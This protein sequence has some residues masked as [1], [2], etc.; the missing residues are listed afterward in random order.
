MA[1]SPMK[2]VDR[3][4]ALLRYFSVR[5]PELGLSELARLASQDKTTTL[6]CLTALERNGFVEQDSVSRKYRLGLA[7]INL[8]RL[9]EQSF[10]MQAVITPY[11]DQLAKITGETTHATLLSGSELLTAF[12]S[13][14]DRAL[15]VHIDPTVILPVHA[16]ASGIIIAAFASEDIRKALLDTTDFT[17]F[18]EATMINSTQF[19]KHVAEARTLG[20]AHVFMTYE[21]DVI[22][23]AAPIFGS[24][25]AP[26]GAIAVAAVS[27][28]H[29]PTL[30][31]IIE[32]NLQQTARDITIALGGVWPQTLPLKTEQA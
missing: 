7:P 14:P 2:S 13:E 3:A 17:A 30:A 10:P 23:T 28:R 1:I 8:A 27:T 6:R 19:E 24:D 11:L 18:T 16:T 21:A 12:V 5:S 31:Q 22:G 4:L 29:D 32:T 9:R 25:A 15:R 20:I 26:I